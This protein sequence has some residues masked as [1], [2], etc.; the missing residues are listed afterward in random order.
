MYRS[1][2]HFPSK[3]DKRYV[4]VRERIIIVA[5]NLLSSLICCICLFCGV[6]TAVKSAL[7]LC[8][9]AV[10][11]L[12]FSENFHLMY[13]HGKNNLTRNKPGVTC[14]PGSSSLNIVKTSF[15]T[16]PVVAWIVFFGAICF[17]FIIFLYGAPLLDDVR[18]TFALSLLLSL[19]TF[20]PSAIIV[21]PYLHHI[22]KF[23][24]A[25]NCQ[26]LSDS[27]RILLQTAFISVLGA[28]FGAFV[29]PLDWNRPW[30]EWPLP[31]FLGISLFLLISHLYNIF[32]VIFEAT[33]KKKK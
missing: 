27:E 21:G 24:T 11:L 30:Q 20:L 8:S 12:S 22:M 19:L 2:S 26:S 31:S 23:Y 32:K 15:E 18:K 4:V 3:S 10:V 28:W 17:H 5:L 13:L 33:S 9:Y 1:L 14:L 7:E 16:L 25:N 6:N 29:I